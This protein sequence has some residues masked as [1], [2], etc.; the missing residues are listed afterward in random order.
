MRLCLDE[1]R[2]EVEA[3]NAT[4]EIGEYWETVEADPALL[5]IAIHNLIS[6]GIK[7][8]KPGV[9]PRVEVW[10]ERHGHRRA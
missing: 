7:Y 2:S 10:T 3:Q 4:V 5:K 8:V 6:N 1:M 9:A